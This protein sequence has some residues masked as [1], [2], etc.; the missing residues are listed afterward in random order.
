MIPPLPSSFYGTVNENGENVPVG[1]IITAWIN[2][3]QYGITESLVYLGQSV[4]ALDV[5]GDDPSTVGIIEGGIHGDTV[6]FKIGSNLA[7]LTGVW[8]SGTN[9]LMNLSQGVPLE[10]IYLPLIIN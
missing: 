10:K 9:Q 8:K 1:T 5:P 2:G 4:Y 3:V 7:D 6:V